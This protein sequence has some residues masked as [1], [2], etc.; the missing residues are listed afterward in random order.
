[1]RNLQ[2]VLSVAV[3]LVAVAAG[4]AAEAADLKLERAVVFMRHGIRPPTKATVTPPGIADQE[5]P[6][7]ST[8]YGHLT[9]HGTEALNKLGTY[10]RE[11]WIGR[12]LL[13][14]AC[15][16]A[17]EVVIWSDTDERTIRTGDAMAAFLFPGCNVANGHFEEGKNDPLFHPM[18]GP[19][20][21]DGAKAKASILQAIGSIEKLRAEHRPQFD[22]LQRVL[23]CCAPAVCT[24]A[25][26]AAGCKLADLPGEVFYKEGN[27]RPELTG[28]FD[29]GAS[30]AQSLALA[31]AEG[32]PMEQVGWGRASRED[33]ETMLNLHSMK[34]DAL[35]R[36]EYMA[37]RG[38]RGFMTRIVDALE[39][40]KDNGAKVTVLVGH[41][42]NIGD[43][44]GVLNFTWRVASY[45]ADTAPPGG[46]PVFELLS[47]A[48]GVK[49]VRVVY[50]SQTMDQMRNLTVLDAAHPPSLQALEISGC[51][52]PADRTLCT[53]ADFSKL[54]RTKLAS[55]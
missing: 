45:P 14:A 27:D 13:K 51:T 31:Y 16:A 2:R 34:G 5:W 55:N 10:Q 30:A 21:I 23:G 22:I 49:Y 11:T 29:F 6:A 26:L 24:K 19:V 41:D 18:E 8:P 52:T 47:D 25:G 36:P 3:V 9:P 54:V 32:L 20:K 48:A 28:P 53:L 46:G 7:W 4:F 37:L 39:G 43:L 50:V 1:M 35:Q 12:G 44:S 38:A 42:T 17:G 33:I 15:P 40:G